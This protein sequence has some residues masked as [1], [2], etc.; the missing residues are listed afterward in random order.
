MHNDNAVNNNHKGWSRPWSYSAEHLKNR[1]LCC[2]V[3]DANLTKRHWELILF[4]A[5]FFP[6]MITNLHLDHIRSDKIDLHSSV[7][8]QKIGQWAHSAAIGK[9]AHK[10]HFDI[11]QMSNLPLYGVHI[12]QCLQAPKGAQCQSENQLCTS[13]NKNNQ[14]ISNQGFKPT[15]NPKPYSAPDYAAWLPE[16]EVHASNWQARALHGCEQPLLSDPQF[17]SLIATFEWTS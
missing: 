4:L 3:S 10:S 16:L 6:P 7:L 11:I 5:S 12:K 2:V 14:L 17:P 15:L 13:M 1:G 8:S 9:I